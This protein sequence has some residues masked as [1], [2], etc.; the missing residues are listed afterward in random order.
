MKIK[1]HPLLTEEVDFSL[2]AAQRVSVDETESLTNIIG[3]NWINN[4]NTIVGKNATG[5]TTIM[6]LVM[7]I[8][9]LLLENKSIT[10]TRL[11][12][13]VNSSGKMQETTFYRRY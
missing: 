13:S 9:E 7:G 11:Q 5:K 12:E 1:N 8:L 3:R 6:K 10:Q 4:I 2:L